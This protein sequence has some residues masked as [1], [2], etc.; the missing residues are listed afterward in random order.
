MHV[1]S[2][3]PRRKTKERA[4]FVVYA[5]EVRSVGEVESL[6]RDLH[7]HPLAHFVL[8]GQAGV[9]VVIIRAEPGVARRPDGPF[10]RRVI[11]AVDFSSGEQI[12]RMSAVVTENWRQLEP[13]QYGLFPGTIEYARDHHLVP[14]IK[15]GE[16]AVEVDI[17]RILRP[18]VAI[19]IRRCVEGFTVGV[20]PKEREVTRGSAF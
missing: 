7:I 8:P 2:C 16:T 3:E 1:K 11:V 14:L 6:R 15:F 4:H 18:V 9:E 13:R 10:I 20:I 5:S 12:E 19:E 17:R